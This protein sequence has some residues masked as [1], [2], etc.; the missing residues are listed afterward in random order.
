MI[1]PNP[2]RIKN[3]T[4]TPNAKAM[5]SLTIFIVLLEIFI[6]VTT[7]DGLS[8]IITTSAASI[9]ASEPRPPIAIPMSALVKTGASLM[10]SPANITLPLEFVI[11]S[12]NLF[13]LSSGKSSA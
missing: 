3:S 2:P 5:F 10:P 11:S 1:N 7:L 4:F 9:A 6:A 12:S 13:T 8:S